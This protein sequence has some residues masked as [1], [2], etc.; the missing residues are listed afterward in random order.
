MLVWLS[1]SKVYM[2]CLN[3][4]I[5]CLLPISLPWFN[6]SYVAVLFNMICD[7]ILG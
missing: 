3:D 4:D 1:I 6:D 2:Q 5:M 7:A